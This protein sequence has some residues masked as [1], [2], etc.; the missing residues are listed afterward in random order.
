MNAE[1]MYYT[2]KEVAALFRV[3]PVQVIRWAKEGKLR[4][5]RTPGGQYRF[6]CAVVDA[7]LAGDDG[8]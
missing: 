2:P 3:G 4:A 1:P 5:I 8:V 7:L 6:P